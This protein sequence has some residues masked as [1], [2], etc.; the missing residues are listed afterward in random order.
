MS[1]GLTDPSTFWGENVKE[2]ILKRQS[3]I[4]PPPHP[5]PQR[6]VLVTRQRE[7]TRSQCE[8]SHQTLSTPHTVE[9]AGR[10]LIF[11]LGHQRHR[12]SS[13]KLKWGWRKCLQAPGLCSLLNSKQRNEELFGQEHFK[14]LLGICILWLRY[15]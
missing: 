1:L 6:R 7:V 2:S 5:L 13:D 9:K 12:K 10:I 11:N 3:Y 15:I 14:F 8:L 4:Y